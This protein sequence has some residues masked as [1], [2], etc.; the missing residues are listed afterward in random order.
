MINSIKS[1]SF[2]A[3]NNLGAGL[4]FFI[5]LIVYILTLEPTTSFWDCGEYI[6]TAHKIQ[7]GHPPGAPFF[8]IVA[9][10]FSNLAFGN[11]SNV[12]WMIN[13]MSALCS[14]L[15]IMFLFWIITQLTQK[16][17]QKNENDISLFSKFCII[18][19]GVIGSLMYT[20]SDSFWFSAVEGEVYAMS[21]LFTAIVFWSILKWEKEFE[22][23]YAN[24]W[25]VFIAFLIGLSVGVHMLNLLAIPAITSIYLY[26]KWHTSRWNSYLKFIFI[27][28]IGVG[29]LGLIFYVV[30]PQ[31]VNLFGKTEL[32]FVNELGFNFNSGTLTFLLFLISLIIGGLIISHRKNLPNLNTLI[33][34]FLVFLIGYSSFFVLIIR[35]NANTPIDENSPEDAV[36]L[37]AYLNREQYGSHPL[38]YGQSFNSTES[39]AIDGSPVY[40]QGYELKSTTRNF[41]WKNPDGKL[42]YKEEF[43]TKEK[44][45][46]KKEELEKEHTKVLTFEINDKYV[47]S[48]GRKEWKTTYKKEDLSIFPRM[49]SNNPLHINGRSSNDGYL[50]WSKM[51]GEKISGPNKKTPSFRENLRFFWNYQI[52]HMYVRYFMWNFSGKQN[53]I[54][55]HGDKFNGNWITGINF[56]DNHLLGLGPQK[57]IPDHFK[58]NAGHNTYFLL[59]FLLGFFGLIFHLIKRKKDFWAIFLLFFFTGIAIVIQLNQTPYQPRERDYAYVGSF[60]AF[61]IWAGIGTFGILELIKIKIIDKIDASQKNLAKTILISIS[62]FLLGIPTIMACQNWDDHD[63]SNRYTARDFAK[64]YLSSCEPNAILFT[65][66][67]NDTFPLWYVQEVE[68]FRTDVRVVNLSLLNTDWYIDQ[69]KK[70]AYDGKAVPFSIERDLYKQGTR[71]VIYFYP[72]STLIQDEK[73]IKSLEYQLEIIGTQNPQQSL[74][75]RSYLENM[76]QLISKKERGEALNKIGEILYIHNEKR[77]DLFFLDSI[78]ASETI[79]DLKDFNQWIKSD[80]SYSKIHLSKNKSFVYSPM[81]KLKIP[82][83]KETVLANNIIS[84][85]DF[86]LI[87]DSLLIDFSKHQVRGLDKKSIMILDLIEKNNWERP[88]CFAITIRDPNTNPEPFLFLNNYL[89][90]DG[91]VYQLVPIKNTNNESGRINSEIIYDNIMREFEWGGIDISNNIY[92]DETNARMIRN[93]KNIFNRLTSQLIKENKLNKADS[94]IQKSLNILRPELIPLEIYDMPLLEN[95]YDLIVEKKVSELKNNITPDSSS[96]NFDNLNKLINPLI[97]RY[98]QEVKYFNSFENEDIQ[99]NWNT[100]SQLIFATQALNALYLLKSSIPNSLNSA[101]ETENGMLRME[102]NELISKYFQKTIELIEDLVKTKY[103][104]EIENLL[105]LL[106]GYAEISNTNNH[107]NLESMLVDFERISILIN[108][109]Q[110]N[111]PNTSSKSPENEM[112]SCVTEVLNNTLTENCANYLNDFFSNITSEEELE[113]AGSNC[114]EIFE[115]FIEQQM[116]AAEEAG[117]L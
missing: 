28:I 53:D 38:I 32:Y 116:Q 95:Y 52:K 76:F 107:P 22:K 100:Q 87:E 39:S 43:S 15:T 97:I 66:G 115:M 58:N 49:W 54:Q 18:F 25:L 117:R 8:V 99:L 110:N 112:C 68:G 3:L 4:V 45:L 30:V 5:A 20:F 44:A 19:S 46:D 65:M 70:D 63:R 10:F 14:A 91:M 48:D 41:K 77:H 82:V 21:S 84:E 94:L 75:L 105:I 104:S 12:A 34:S 11:L 17:I 92:I 89:Q 31:I 26:K 27:N 37:L 73:D 16:M 33:L 98:N 57:K 86:N 93:F 61:C 62:I 47:I 64:N 80:Q 85:E 59:P 36:S 72:Y 71:D 56:I 7:V 111:S 23:T 83:N 114:P 9:N 96:I 42:V 50:G 102:T 67:D 113:N 1:L 79:F 24:R 101:I 109:N 108:S 88:I 51:L 6:A 81:Q 55:G 13:F 35:S 90:L 74:Q 40:V 2:S 103:S 106:R 78:K 69:M 29:I 60:F